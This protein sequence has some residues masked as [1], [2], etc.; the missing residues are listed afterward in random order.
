[1]AGSKLQ[2]N[3][4][5]LCLTA[6]CFI[7]M[8]CFSG[9]TSHID[10]KQMVGRYEAVL[11]NARDVITLRSDASFI[12]ELYYRTGK[13]VLN[14]G[15]WRLLDNSISLE[16]GLALN[17]GFPMSETYVPTLLISLPVQTRFCHVQSFGIEEFAVFVKQQ[18][19]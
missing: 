7:A 16:N 13:K 3:L 15:R 19:D 2:K 11:P 18:T 6:A 12:E 17:G 5:I 8:V 1:M 10:P 4:P 14:S 9:C